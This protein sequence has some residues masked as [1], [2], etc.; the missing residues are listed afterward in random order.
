MSK[1]RPVTSGVPQG[2]IFGPV[3]LNTFAGDM[4]SRIECTLSKFANDT[5]LCGAVNTLEG[6]D[7][8][9]R[10]LN[11][12]ERWAGANGFEKVWPPLGKGTH[13]QMFIWAPGCS[14]A[15]GSL[16]DHINNKAEMPHKGQGNLCQ[17]VWDA[18]RKPEAC[19]ELNLART[20]KDNKKG[21]FK[22]TSSKRKTRENV[23]LLLNEVGAL[24]T[25]NAEKEELLNVTFASVFTAKARLQEPQTPEIV[26]PLAVKNC[27][28]ISARISHLDT[29]WCYKQSHSENT[30]Y[31]WTKT[32]STLMPENKTEKDLVRSIDPS[33]ES[34]SGGAT[35]LETIP[36]EAIYVSYLANLGFIEQLG[37]GI[38]PPSLLDA[39]RFVSA[40]IFLT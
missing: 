9:Q 25:E 2:S 18:M 40:L 16:W 27:N 29:N 26:E 30:C 17:Q 38:T 6:R 14:V 24:V 10:D 15:M 32:G 37:N 5:E 28:D 31:H 22:Y 20:V 13:L 36:A 8:I 35:Q 39:L 4:G 23:G 19:L 1:W 12:L 7:A 33:Y 34:N 21:F 11:R 3:L